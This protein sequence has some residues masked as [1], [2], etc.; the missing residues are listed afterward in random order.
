MSS[1]Y[2]RREFCGWVVAVLYIGV[3]GWKGRWVAVVLND[4]GY[5]SARVYK[6]L[7]EIVSAADFAVIGLDVPI[8]L[9]EQPP[10]AS[11]NL[12][13]AKLG[14]RSSS[15]FAAPPSF[16][17]DPR[18]STR[19]AASDESKRR[20][21]IGIGAQAFALM[22]NIR[23]A[24]QVAGSDSRVY[25]VHPEF[26]FCLMNAEKPLRFNKKCWNVREERVALL[27]KHRVVLPKMFSNEVG[28]VPVDDIL[29][30]AAVAWSARRIAKNGAV[31]LPDASQRIGSI[32][33]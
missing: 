21:G 15:V 14:A 1:G 10:R 29:D 27:R 17:L 16:C 6:T 12:V 26:S 5:V 7:D 23:C 9:P 18:W 33:G 30:A 32:W 28:Q 3:D 4:E 13:R 20:F 22:H 31:A 19:A 2:L 8:G 25:E 11:D 24:D